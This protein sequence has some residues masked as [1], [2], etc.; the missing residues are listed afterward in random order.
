VDAVSSTSRS[1]R[2]A[3]TAWRGSLKRL[4]KSESS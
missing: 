3:R 2:R 4:E 1:I